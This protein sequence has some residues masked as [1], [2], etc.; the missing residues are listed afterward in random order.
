MNRGLAVDGAVG[1]TGAELCA[2]FSSSN[3]FAN[4]CAAVGDADFSADGAFAPFSAGEDFLTGS[5][6]SGAF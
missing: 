5:F 6:G 3:T 1:V 2:F 4:F